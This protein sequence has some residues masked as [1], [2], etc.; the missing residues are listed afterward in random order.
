LRWDFYGATAGSKFPGRH[1]RTL[2]SRFAPAFM[3]ATE[4]DRP[5]MS[6]N[7][8]ALSHRKKPTTKIE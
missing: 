1:S 3:L 6:A 4:F 7:G 2:L 5:I 8:A